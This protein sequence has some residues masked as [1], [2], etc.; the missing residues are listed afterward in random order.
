MKAY[1]ALGIAGPATGGSSQP[2]YHDV[3]RDNLSSRV[4]PAAPAPVWHSQRCSV[5]SLYLVAEKTSALLVTKHAE[6]ARGTLAMD[7]M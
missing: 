2:K 5:I 4:F 7:K 6:G 3:G 1:V